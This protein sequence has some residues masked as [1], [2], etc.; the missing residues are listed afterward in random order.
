MNMKVKICGITNKSDL[1]KIEKTNYD[2]MGFIN[3]DRSKRNVSINKVKQRE[4]E[5]INKRSSTLVLEPENAYDVILKCNRLQIFNVQLHSLTS[6]DIKYIQWIN[7]YHNFEKLNITRAIGLQDNIDKNKQKQLEEYAK[8]CDNI[9]L[10][11]VKD[12]LTGGTNKQIPIETAI[13]ASK[14]IKNAN[15]NTEVSLAGG[16]NYEY[17]EN[18][19]DQLKYF[20]RIDLNSGVEIKAGKKNIKSIKKVLSLFDNWMKKI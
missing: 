3:I 15:K 19:Y 2:K 5:L 18:I 13:Q 14:I 11:Y 12:G 9:L 4:K 7:Q 6:F 20:D 10:D 17:L 1:K 16:L 8:R